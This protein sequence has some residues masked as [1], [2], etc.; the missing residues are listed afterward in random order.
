MAD[1]PLPETQH[2]R[3]LKYGLNVVLTTVIMIALA[4][5]LIYLAETR[6]RRVDTSGQNVNSLKEQTKNILN[7]LQSNVTLVSLYT[8]AG[9]DRSENKVD[10]TGQ[11]EDLLDEYKRNSKHIEVELIDPVANPTKVD[12]LIHKVTEKYGGE[13]KKYKEFVESYPA[14]YDKML[15][16]VKEQDASFGK[17]PFDQIKTVALK[18]AL[19][20]TYNTINGSLPLL[21][22]TKQQTDRRLKLKPPDYKGVVDIITLEMTAISSSLDAVIGGFE[23]NLKDPNLPTDFKK[24]FTDNLPKLRDIKKISDSLNDQIGKLGEL[25]LDALRQSL[26]SEGRDS[27]LVMGENDLKVLSFN[28]VWK[29][30][31]DRKSAPGSDPIKPQFA[32]EQQITTAILTLT[33]KV[34]P[35]VVFIRPGGPPLAGTGTFPGGESPFA[36]AA[37]RLRDYNFDVL[38][39]DISGMW[40]MQSQMQGMPAAPE[41]SDAEIKD[42]VWVVLDFPAQG[43]MGM[44]PPSVS[45]KLLE[46]LSNGGS[47]LVM[48]FRQAD[49]LDPALAP[50]GVKL[51][52]DMIAVKQRITDDSGREGDPIEQAERRYQSVFI[53]KEFGDHLLTKPL[54]SLD[55][56][57]LSIVPVEITS[58][59]GYTAT[60]ILPVPTSPPSWSTNVTNM[61]GNAELKFD[62]KRGDISPPIFGGAVVEKAGGG[63]LVVLGSLEFAA[64]EMVLRPDRSLDGRG[65]RNVPRFPGNGELFSNCVYWLA[66]ME[67]MIAI[68]PSA[69]QISRIAPMS[70]GAA[71]AW[72]IGVLIVGLP[73]LVIVAGLMM[74]FVRR[75]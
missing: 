51:K 75:D 64:D 36:E 2:Q 40:A 42:A 41:P 46:H 24:Y 16:G 63:R 15:A 68:A 6:K 52:T 30:E 1:Q 48:A 37:R 53:V 28:Q 44:P 8:R 20:D 34:K 35:K 18:N 5:V 69:T 65:Y 3:W 19:I 45:A 22:K 21:E 23:A 47:A 60:P 62:P 31:I 29:N 70:D 11:V 59:P 26:T 14:Q 71:H 32:G 54:R 72:N 38:E 67:P 25:K 27:I 17:L 13:V 39:K 61:T 55:A 50:W 33:A 4:V 49:S 7:D 74:Y 66:R 57:F 73:G 10:Y 12:D 43:Q 58:K 9:T 56:A